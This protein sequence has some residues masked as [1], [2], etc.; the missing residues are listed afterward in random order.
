[1]REIKADGGTYPTTI[2]DEFGVCLVIFDG[3]CSQTC[4]TRMKLEDAGCHGSMGG[5]GAGSEGIKSDFGRVDP[6]LTE[7]PPSG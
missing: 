7:R 2:Q 4:G 3:L 6:L 5:G 1:M